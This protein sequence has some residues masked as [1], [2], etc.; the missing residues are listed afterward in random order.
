MAKRLSP[1]GPPAAA[2]AVGMN[3]G[4]DDGI[5]G[6]AGV[7][8]PGGVGTVEYHITGRGGPGGAL[9]LC[10]MIQLAQYSWM[11]LAPARCIYMWWLPTRWV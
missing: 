11:W 2:V 4:N 9:R 7:V 6:G 1:D 8:V 5:E 3:V 10:Y